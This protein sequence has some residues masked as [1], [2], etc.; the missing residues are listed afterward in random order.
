MGSF[1][2]PFPKPPPHLAVNINLNKDLAKTRRKIRQ[3]TEEWEF[4]EHPQVVD[5]NVWP[6]YL[7]HYAI[8]EEFYDTQ[9]KNQFT[10][11]QLDGSRS[12]DQNLSAVLSNVEAIL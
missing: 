10:L 2:A 11:I 6:S 3:Q 9:L 4:K 1:W 12:M 8:F 7:R 5:L